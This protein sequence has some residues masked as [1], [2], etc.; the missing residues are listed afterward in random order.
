MKKKGNLIKLF[1]M[2][3][4]VIIVAGMIVSFLKIDKIQL[5]IKSGDFVIV[6]YELD[7]EKKEMKAIEN[8]KE[9]LA[10]ILKTHNIQAEIFTIA[11]PDFTAYKTYGKNNVSPYSI[12]IADDSFFN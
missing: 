6:S 7:N 10:E 9:E 3:G 1:P 4:M 12:Q 8:K 5:E 11:I 2:I